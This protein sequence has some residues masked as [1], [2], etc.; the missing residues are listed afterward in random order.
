MNLGKQRQFVEPDA[1]VREHVD[2]M[3]R[4]PDEAWRELE[5]RVSRIE[6]IVKAYQVINNE[7]NIAHMQE[8]FQELR[9]IHQAEVE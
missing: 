8:L 9:R 6:P 2:W 7:I 4:Y 5:R 3:T 1:D